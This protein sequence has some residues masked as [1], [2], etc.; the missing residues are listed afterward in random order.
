MLH[1]GLS[2]RSEDNPK[3]RSRQMMHGCPCLPGDRRIQSGLRMES[4]VLIMVSLN[5][6][7]RDDLLA[8]R[9]A[10]DIVMISGINAGFRKVQLSSLWASSLTLSSA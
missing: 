1:V 6:L 10:N 8:W 7:L 2:C 4:E 9:S 5:N 3:G